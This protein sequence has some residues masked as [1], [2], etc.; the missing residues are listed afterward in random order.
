MKLEIKT[1]IFKEMVSRS[2]KGASMNKLIPLTGLMAIRLT[3]NRLD[4]ITTD[5]SNYLYIM[6]K[7]VV[8]DDFYV[9][10][11]AEQF[12]KL[13]SRMT[14]ENII[15]EVVD[16]VLNVKGNGDYKIEVPMDEE[17]EPIVFPDPMESE[18][19]EGS[20]EV[21]LTTLKLLLTTLKPA[22]AT[23]MEVPVYTRYYLGKR[24]VA[25]DT[26]KITS[27][28]VDVLKQEPLLMSAETMNLLDVMTCEKIQFH[29][30]G[31][32][33]I[34]SSPDCIVYGHD[35]E[36]IDDYA[37]DAISGVIDE[38]LE[39]FCKLNKNS[40][41]AVLDRISLFV[42]QYDNKAV[43]F[44]FAPKGVDI[45]SKSSSG[46]ETL[47][48]LESEGF[49]PYTCQVDIEMFTQQIKANTSDAIE[50]YY[51]NDSSLKIKDGNITQIIALLAEE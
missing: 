43:T 6:Q 1:D 46:V 40:L 39:S 22:L 41:L 50:L 8:G 21:N 32:N 19:V 10:I 33:L 34:F 38:E 9:V 14:C 5:A 17:G 24:V 4:L 15:L 30:N 49:K 29:S 31:H 28:D 26:F 2:V 13:I 27:M 35:A 37:I 20:T 12:A 7:N 23:T 3:D 48:Y 42:G 36:G 25:T 51:G 18:T 44:T 45:S 16:G 47:E 11:Q